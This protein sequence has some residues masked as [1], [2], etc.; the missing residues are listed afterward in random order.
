MPGLGSLYLITQKTP[1][2][3]LIGGNTNTQQRVVDQ[4]KN[5]PGLCAVRYPGLEAFWTR[6]RPVD[7]PLRTFIINDFRQ[8][9]SY[10]AFE[11]LVRR[12]D[13]QGAHRET[14]QSTS[15]VS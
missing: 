9:D 2:T 10:G 6:G 3:W 4:V 11:I 13:K 15:A 12:S 8:V 1:P 14:D 5:V 7:W